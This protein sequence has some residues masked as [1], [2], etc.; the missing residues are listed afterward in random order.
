MRSAGRATLLLAT[1]AALTVGCGGGG[2]DA[3]PGTGTGLRVVATTSILGDVVASIVGEHAEVEVLVPAGVDPHGFSPSAR[4]AARLREADLVVA[5]GLGL[6]ES[7]QDAL[8]AAEEDGV[9]VLHVA[10][11]VDPLAVPEGEHGDGQG[12]HAEGSEGEAH[13]DDHG[14]LDPHVWL[15]PVRMAEAAELIGA[16]LADLA[17]APA[18]GSWEERGAAYAD[19]LRAVDEEIGGLLAGIPPERRLLVTS[20]DNLRYFA[21]RYD[22]EVLGAVIPGTSSQSQPSTREVADLAA[23]IERRDVPAIFTDVAGGTGRLAETLAAEAG[24]D[25]AVVEVYTDALGQQGSGA[26]SLVELL[27]TNAERIADALG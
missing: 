7:L 17:P 9:E 23:L 8:A 6:E 12:T 5:N 19:E 25:V 20:H 4:D 22:F 2:G 11:E 14:A 10:E 16:R 13:D 26:E 3:P 1:L 18:G 27:R 24:R 15:D 21:E